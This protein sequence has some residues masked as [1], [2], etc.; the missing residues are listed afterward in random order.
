[1]V[2]SARLRKHVQIMSHRCCNCQKPFTRAGSRRH[3]ERYTCWKQLE[4]GHFPSS[5]A[6]TQVDAPKITHPTEKQNG[7]ERGKA[8]RLQEAKLQTNRTQ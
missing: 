3:H 6:V 7:I 8:F 2:L 5:P 4:K 1:M